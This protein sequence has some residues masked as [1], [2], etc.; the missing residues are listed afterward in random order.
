MHL[1][2][3]KERGGGV[4]FNSTSHSVDFAFL[5]VSWMHDILRFRALP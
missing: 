4:Q 3:N 1:Y 2:R 5:F